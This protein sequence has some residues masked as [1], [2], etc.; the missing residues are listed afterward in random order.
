MDMKDS[1]VLVV[2][3]AGGLGSRVCR[4]VAE[5]GANVVIVYLKPQEEARSEEL[6]TELS[7]LGPRAMAIQADMAVQADIDRVLERTL[8][9]FERIDVLINSTGMNKPIPFPDVEAIDEELWNQILNSNL[10]GP[11]LTI[12]SLTPIMRRQGFGRIVNVASVAGLAPMG[13]SIAYAVAK[14]GL[15]H[16]TRCMAKALGPD[17]L[18][19]SV[20]PGMMAGVGMVA[21][22]PQSAADSYGQS[23]ILGRTTYAKDV[24]D[25]IVTLVRTD[26]I[27]GQTLVVDAGV[28]YH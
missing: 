6:V 8:D 25:A 23:S 15:V 16:L 22:F 7:S 5:A 11:F 18:V 10:T 4:A 28:V 2:G 26:S 12:R 9:E 24:V 14:A 3:G 13:S 1:C 27:T 19:N 21:D 20:S 17:I